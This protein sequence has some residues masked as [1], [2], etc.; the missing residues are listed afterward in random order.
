MIKHQLAR[1]HIGQV[2]RHRLYAMRGVVYDVETSAGTGG[3]P[4]AEDAAPALLYRLL[5]E[6]DGVP[7]EACIAEQDLLPDDSGEPVS[8][9]GVGVLFEEGE[10]GGY[11][12][13]RHLIN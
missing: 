2:I 7:Y 12:H 8:H 3:A 6:D 9:P 13:R 5:A 1:Y 11:R 10:A 4:G